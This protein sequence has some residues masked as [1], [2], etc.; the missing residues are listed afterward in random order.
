MVLEVF[1]LLHFLPIHP[2]FYP[3]IFTF[4]R[5]NDGWTCLCIKLCNYG[6]IHATKIMLIFYDLTFETVTVDKAMNFAYPEHELDARIRD[7][8]KSIWFGQ[9][10]VILK[11]LG[12]HN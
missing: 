6:A 1:L 9:I 2:Y 11:C 12:R 4:N 3:S 8:C 5:P 7:D 10:T